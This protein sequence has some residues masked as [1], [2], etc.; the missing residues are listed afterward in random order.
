MKKVFVIGNVELAY[1]CLR[2]VDC[3]DGITMDEDCLSR[4]TGEA[5][6]IG[7]SKKYKIAGNTDPSFYSRKHGITPVLLDKTTALDFI[8]T[9]LDLVTI[10][11][12]APV[13]E[14]EVEAEVDEITLNTYNHSAINLLFAKVKSQK[15]SPKNYFVIDTDGEYSVTTDSTR[16][17]LGNLAEIFA[18]INAD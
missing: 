18:E 7:T 16:E 5:I 9:V 14:A 2:F 13:I 17:N 1:A 8:Q 6:S 12:P 4:T 3:L 10:E 15:K 11:A